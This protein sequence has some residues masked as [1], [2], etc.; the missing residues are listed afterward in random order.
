MLAAA[1]A[2]AARVGLQQHMHSGSDAGRSSSHHE[3]FVCTTCNVARGACPDIES[4]AA[5]AGT[6]TGGAVFRLLHATLTEAGAWV[7]APAVAGEGATRAACAAADAAAD[8]RF[9][10]AARLAL[11]ADLS[12]TL[13]LTPV[14]C[15]AACSFPH[16]VALRG[17][18]RKGEEKFVY[19]FGAVGD[20]ATVDG[21]AR[22]ATEYCTSPDGYSSSRTRPTCLRGRV[23]ARVPPPGGRCLVDAS[24]G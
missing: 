8:P 16:T 2:A 12:V 7:P 15:L 17:R 14:R 5:E 18:G 23:L 21:L 1:A 19:Q 11:A 24:A 6:T 3:C 4:L 22:M 20:R 9:A 10:P 13:T